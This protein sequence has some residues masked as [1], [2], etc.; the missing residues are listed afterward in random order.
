MPVLLQIN[1]CANSG[2]TGRI[3]EQVGELAISSGWD[4]YIAYGREVNDST[5][6]LYKVGSKIDLVNHILLTRLFD[7][8]GFGSKDPTKALI[9]FIDQIRP[10]IIHLHNIHG[11]FIN[12]RVLFDYLNS[13]NT[14]IVWTLHDSWSF[15]G[16]CGQF[17]MANC[18]KWKSGCGDCPQYKE[19]YP[20]SFVDRSLSNFQIKKELFTKKHNIHLVPVS[21]WLASCVRESFFSEADIQVINNGVDLKAFTPLGHCPQH[22]KVRILGVAS[23][24]TEYK[25]I[26]DFYQLRQLLPRDRY[27]IILVGL[28]KQQISQLPFGIIGIE[29]TQSLSSLAELYRSADVFVNPSYCD[30]F[31]TVNL[32][33]IASGTPVV[34]YNVGGSPETIDNRTGAVVPVGDIA[35]VA[36]WIINYLKLPINE[37]L[38]YRSN[39][40]R[41][42]ELLYNKDDCFIKY[43]KLYYSLLGV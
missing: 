29:R 25:G 11:Y 33:S 27:E 4:S 23:V 9:R 37:V 19:E 1:S 20:R 2:S 31:P 3:A 32:E 12:I 42:A 15:T 28:T 17:L 43:L 24:W 39:C 36:N 10:N 5:S 38:D 16:H 41:R 13:I 18:E 8:H 30:T 40:R 34:T 6:H 7:R 26:K 35:G 21:H 22:E 14:P